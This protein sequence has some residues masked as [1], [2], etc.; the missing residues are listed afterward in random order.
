MVQP[1]R[2]ERFKSTDRIGLVLANSGC[3]VPI[4]GF[5]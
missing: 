3:I 4:A 1:D 5:G 2:L